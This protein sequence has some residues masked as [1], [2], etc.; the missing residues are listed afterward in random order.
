MLEIQEELGKY[1]IR[2][3]IIRSLHN[4]KDIVLAAM[5]FFGTFVWNLWGEELL[6]I[7]YGATNQVWLLVQN[8]STLHIML[9]L[10]RLRKKMRHIR[11]F[12]ILSVPVISQDRKWNYGWDAPLRPLVYA[13]II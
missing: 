13:K 8:N 12:L 6:F 4:L 9:S 11:S 7:H 1:W 10:L 2:V 3:E 5:L